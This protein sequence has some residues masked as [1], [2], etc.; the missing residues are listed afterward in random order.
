MK[1]LS[2]INQ[3]GPK[4]HHKCP[5]KRGRSRSIHRERCCEDRAESDLAT[6]QGMMSQK[7]L[8]EARNRFFPRAFGGST[9]LLTPQFRTSGL[10]NSK[11]INT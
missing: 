8:E 10:Q 5:Y 4:C 9:A 2:W 3:V 7:K 11:I 1:K 6:S